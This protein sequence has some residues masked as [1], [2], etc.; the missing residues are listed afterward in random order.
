M[1]YF[2]Y[3]S[4]AKDPRLA[5]VAAGRDSYQSGT[6]LVD[7]ETGTIH[8]GRIGPF[9]EHAPSV[10]DIRD[11][12]SSCIPYRVSAYPLPTAKLAGMRRDPLA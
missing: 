11:L 6:H 9:D 10:S 12:G 4:S 8:L 5:I 7:R 1:M 2:H 3:T